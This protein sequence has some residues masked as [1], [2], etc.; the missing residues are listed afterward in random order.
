[1]LRCICLS[2]LDRRIYFQYSAST[3]WRQG[4]EMLEDQANSFW[5]ASISTLHCD[6]TQIILPIDTKIALKTSI[7]LPN[8]IQISWIR[9]TAYMTYV[10]PMSYITYVHQISYALLFLFVFP[11]NHFELPNRTSHKQA[12]RL[13]WLVSTQVFARGETYWSHSA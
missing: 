5:K 9:V 1:M 8:L 4:E 11:W 7:N 10:R 3:I 6:R 12:W 2:Y 13:K